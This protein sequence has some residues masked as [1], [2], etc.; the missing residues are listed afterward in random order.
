MG[1]DFL[2]PDLPEE[3]NSSRQVGGV[4]TSSQKNGSTSTPVE[5]DW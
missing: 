3:I 1:V 2:D 4:L 5:G